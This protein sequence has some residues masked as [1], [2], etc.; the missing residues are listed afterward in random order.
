MKLTKTQI[1]AILLVIFF[2]TSSIFAQNVG[3]NSTGATPDASASLDVVATDK[4]VLIPRVSISNALTAA[5]V[6]SPET[7]LLV[8]NT[9]AAISSGSGTGFYFW[10]G[11]QW[12]KLNTG[13]SSSGGWELT[14]NSGTTAGT[15]F[16][17]TTDAVD[18]VIKTNNTERGR[19]YS[20]GELLF[21]GTYASGSA[22]NSGAGT[23]MFW[24]PKKG[25]FTAGRVTSTQWND[26]NLGDYSAI[27]GYNNTATGDYNLVAGES[28]S[29]TSAGTHNIIGG[30]DNSARG[31]YNIIG[32]ENNDVHASAAGDVSNNIVNGLNND[33]GT[34]GI[35]NGFTNQSTNSNAT[36]NGQSNNI[37]GAN[38]T[39]FG[40]SNTISGDYSM[41]VGAFSTIT[42]DYSAAFGGTFGNTNTIN[43]N[44]SFAF[45][46]SLNIT[47]TGGYNFAF[48][49]TNT[50]SGTGTHNYVF[51]SSNTST[52]LYSFSSGFFNTNGGTFSTSIGVFNALGTGTYNVLLG[53]FLSVSGA[54]GSRTLIGQGVSGAS[55]LA[56]ANDYTFGV[57]YQ[58]TKPTL[59][60]HCPTGNQY[61]NVGIGIDAPAA[62]LDVR[63]DIAENV[64]TSYSMKIVN[65]R[66]S[67]YVGGTRI[68]L[69][70]DGT[71]SFNNVLHG[72]IG[73][74]SD[75]TGAGSFFNYAGVFIGGNV[76]IGTSSPARTLHVSDVMRIEP[77]AS[78]PTGASEGDIY[79][80]STTH[81]L[82]V[83]DGT[84][85]QACW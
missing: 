40:A 2:S 27:F 72:N 13:A 16:I 43:G 48:G 31:D 33:Y 56:V 77:T 36:I 74:Y 78:A 57:G 42:S 44:Y 12:T 59:V 45:G 39:A 75:V 55:P 18:W 50:I 62:K 70:V 58:H 53:A 83:Y 64:Q 60:V 14:G 85:W 15:N 17:G 26:A 10:D 51:G 37:T 6:T 35:I 52:G 38:G 11:S 5:P 23:R 49:Q 47:S 67:T 46:G 29:I 28:N 61:G 34:Y 30:T 66:T 3:I 81:K 69:H 76:G 84:A 25:S 24:S 20:T 54:G 32:G 63:D 80:N 8:Y 1:S 82:M 22:I 9:N 68:G 41:A 7:S 21:Q 73:V 65:T 19:V 71:S 79:M 4:G